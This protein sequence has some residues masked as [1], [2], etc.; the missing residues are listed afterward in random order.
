MGIIVYDHY[1]RIRW[2]VAASFSPRQA[3]SE[4]GLIRSVERRA[5]AMPTESLWSY[6]VMYCAKTLQSE[7]LR[8]DILSEDMKWLARFC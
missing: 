7:I 3:H 5:K 1:D 4:N 2:H 6:D 8:Y